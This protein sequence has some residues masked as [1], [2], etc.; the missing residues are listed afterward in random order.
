L[1]FADVLAACDAV[2]GKLGYGL[3]ADCVA[4]GVGL[5]YPPRETFREDSITAAEAPRYIRAKE[6]P[7]RDFLS[8]D[9]APHLRKLRE[10]PE[11]AEKMPAGGA[12]V[13]ARE[14]LRQ[15]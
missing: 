12:R 2:L 11:P 4:S 15:S 1:R 6:I 14:L 7:I 13:A 9:W 10:L 3:V 8:G 5:L